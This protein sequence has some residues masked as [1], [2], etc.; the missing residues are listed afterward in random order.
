MSLQVIREMERKRGGDGERQQ[1]S[2]STTITTQ[3]QD[4]KD[5]RKTGWRETGGGGLI[6]WREKDKLRWRGGSR[7]GEILGGGGVVGRKVG[8]K[9][10]MG[11]ERKSAVVNTT[12]EKKQVILSC[13][14]II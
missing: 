8:K 2:R 13:L 3:Q 9:E 11:K 7:E 12:C 14:G 5:K 4:G 10:A 1:T 6:K